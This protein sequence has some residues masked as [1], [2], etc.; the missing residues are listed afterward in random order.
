MEFKNRS[1]TSNIMD[2]WNDLKMIQNISEQHMREAHQSTAENIRT[3][4][5]AR[6]SETTKPKVQ[7]VYYGKEHDMYNKI[8]Q[9]NLVCFRCSTYVYMPFI[10]VVKIL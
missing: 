10:N 6:T 5:C 4:H 1:G 2:N 9:Q 3:G 8:K 7:E